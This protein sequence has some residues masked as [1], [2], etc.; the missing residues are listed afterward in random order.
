MAIWLATTMATLS[1]KTCFKT[2]LEDSEKVQLNIQTWYKEMGNT[3]SSVTH[4]LEFDSF[5]LV[6]MSIKTLLTNRQNKKKDRINKP[7]YSWNT[8]SI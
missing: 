5:S 3:C 1:T 4:W 8:S 7:G 6:V 2:K